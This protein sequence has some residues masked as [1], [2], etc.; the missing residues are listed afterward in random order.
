MMF[1]ESFRDKIERQK[2]ARWAANLTE[3]QLYALFCAVGE[4]GEHGL[5]E[6]LEV[7]RQH[8]PKN[9]FT[10]ARARVSLEIVAAF[11]FGS[12][13]GRQEFLD[14]MHP[15]MKAGLAEFKSRQATRTD[16]RV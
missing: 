16:T 15:A 1:S 13:I 5:E 10:Y 7:I 9:P 6:L 12:P 11:G 14:R 2:Y 8:N 3:D 4:I